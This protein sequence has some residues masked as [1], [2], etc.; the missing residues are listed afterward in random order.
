MIQGVPENLFIKFRDFCDEIGFMLSSIDRE[1]LHV[2]SRKKAV[3]LYFI[4]K[5]MLELLQA[6]LDS[7]F[8]PVF[9]GMQMGWFKKSLGE[10][11]EFEPSLQLIDIL[12][13]Q[14]VPEIHLDEKKGQKFL[15]GWDVMIKDATK[16]KK[17]PGGTGLK[18]V[19]SEGIVIGLGKTENSDVMRNLIDKGKYIR[20]ER[21][22]H[23]GKSK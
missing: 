13:E 15:H 18:I 20:S 3:E 6:V 4:P 17:T 7:G 16:F 11:A 5:N 21:R 14:E 2:I 9:V 19:V 8:N 1:S 22:R 23:G 12:S 10:V